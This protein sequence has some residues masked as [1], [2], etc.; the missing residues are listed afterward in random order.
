MSFTQTGFLAVLIKIFFAKKSGKGS[1]TKY[2]KI[3]SP[4]HEFYDKI[5]GSFSPNEAT[6]R[7]GNLII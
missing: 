2:C 7:N 1:L 6:F 5:E 4:D 3:F